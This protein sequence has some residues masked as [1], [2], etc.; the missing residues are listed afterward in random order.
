MRLVCTLNDRQ[1][2]QL[3]SNFLCHEGVEN[4]LELFTNTDWGS[5]DYGTITCRIWIV[6]EERLEVALKCVAE[7][8]KNP[9][10]PKFLSYSSVEN[11]DAV[12]VEV[13]SSQEPPI[14]E[15]QPMGAIT[16]YLIVICS[17]LLIASTFT[18]PLVEKPIPGILGASLYYSRIDKA[19]MYDYPKTYV[20]ADQLIKTYSLKALETPETL[21]AAGKQLF[22]QIQSTPYWQ[23]FYELILDHLKS[24]EASWQINAPLFEKIQEGEVWRLFT[25]CLLHSDI[26]HLFFNMIWLVVLGK[27]MEQRL[28][29]RH[30]LL[31]IFLTGAFSNTAQY[32]MS[33]SNFLGFSGVLC[34]MLAFIWVRQKQ[35]AWEGYQLEAGTFGFIS[36]FILFMFAIQLLSFF[37]EAQM[38]SGLPVAIANTAHLTGA[39]A[40]YILAKTNRFAWSG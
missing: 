39:F 18:P 40:G 15:R 37:M 12:A 7:F 38:G 24:G 34:A 35:A 6:D 36:F 9:D 2:G 4:Q 28:G 25:P 33:G 31:F 17:L 29:K 21:P 16:L 1:R 23:G 11:R 22:K 26:L 10:D 13:L 30:Y 14:I 27:Q 5:L 32:L 8:Q 3:L 19:L 20:L